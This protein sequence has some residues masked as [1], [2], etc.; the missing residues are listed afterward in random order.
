MFSPESVIYR[1]NRIEPILGNVLGEI[2]LHT[3]FSKLKVL[4]GKRQPLRVSTQNMKPQQWM[5]AFQLGCF[6]QGLFSLVLQKNEEQRA[7]GIVEVGL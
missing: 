6:F 1:R 4:A 3:F 7:N 2:Y 5:E